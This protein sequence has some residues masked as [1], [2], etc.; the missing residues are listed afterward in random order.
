MALVLFHITSSQCLHVSLLNTGSSKIQKIF[1]FPVELYLH[2]PI[3]LHGVLFSDAQGQ[4]YL[5]TS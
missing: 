2:F 3:R 4:L 1:L 5:L